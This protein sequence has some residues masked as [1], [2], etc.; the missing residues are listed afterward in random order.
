MVHLQGAWVAQSVE[1]LIL[2]FG[3]GHDPRIVGS[4]P[5]LGSVLSMEPTWDSLFLSAP[6][7]AHTCS[8]SK[9][10]I[11]KLFIH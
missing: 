2:D 7:P 10:K 3:S 8:L 6:L 11:N 5:D 1:C 4:S 9:I